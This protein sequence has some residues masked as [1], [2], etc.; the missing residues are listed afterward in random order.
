[1][2]ALPLLKL[3]IIG[4]KQISKPVAKGIARYCKTHDS[5]ANKI[6]APIGQNVHRMNVILTRIGEGSKRTKVRVLPHE[7]AV[8]LGGEIVA[9][10]F[11]FGTADQE[12]AAKKKKTHAEMERIKIELQFASA[13][14]EE[15]QIQ[16]VRREALLEKQVAKE[17]ADKQQLQNRI[18]SLEDKYAQSVLHFNGT[19]FAI[20]TGAA[21]AVV[22][23]TVV[24]FLS[25]ST[26]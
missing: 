23:G 24:G 2:A 19:P 4:A 9:E 26:R 5:V 10:T 13:A 18:Q 6:V 7:G 8:D 25:W 17:I 15:N 22:A 16:D 14:I 20:S 11:I 1:M 12:A 3:F 21:V